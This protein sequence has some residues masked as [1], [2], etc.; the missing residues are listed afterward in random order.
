MRGRATLRA[1]EGRWYELLFG[2]F[3]T[4]FDFFQTDAVV[5]EEPTLELAQAWWSQYSLEPGY[6]ALLGRLPGEAVN[7]YGDSGGPVLAERGN[8]MFLY[9][10]ING[11]EYSVANVCDYG[12][13]AAVFGPDTMNFL[14]KAR[15]WQDPC[16]CVTERG[17][18]R[19]HTAVRCSGIGEGERRLV[20]TRC[21][22]TS[23]VCIDDGTRVG[24]GTAP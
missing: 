13:F 4:F 9:G 10:V 11:T 22:E 16:G 18:C 6:E 21:E 12:S 14:R 3:D 20:V 1:L 24:C 8:T 7:C 5:G 2:D 23:Q 15:T 17:Q 19:G